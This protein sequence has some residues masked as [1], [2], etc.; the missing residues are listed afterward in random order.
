MGENKF[1]IEYQKAQDSA[2]HHDNLIWTTVSIIWAG[3]LVLL[4]FV[5]NNIKNP[6]LKTILTFISIFGIILI[7]CMC[8]LA[9]VF[10]Y[11]MNQK[12]ECCKNLEE[13]LKF[14]QHRTVKC[15]RCLVKIMISIITLAF[16]LIW[17]SVICTI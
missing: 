6:E 7:L 3:N 1:E 9:F 16:I 11:I 4:G 10:N 17:A 2:E 13:K 8:I 5:L 12:Y 14:Q 15:P